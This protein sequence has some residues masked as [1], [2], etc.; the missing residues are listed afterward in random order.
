MSQKRLIG[1]ICGFAFLLTAS[2]G[3]SAQTIASSIVGTVVDATGAVIPGAHV[4][5][6][7]SGTGAVRDVQS[8]SSGVFRFPNLAPGTYSETVTANGFK[9]QNTT[10]I[11]LS[12]SETRD[13]GKIALQVGQT[14]EEV[15]VTAATTPIQT[16]SSDVSHTIGGNQLDALPLAGRDLFG[17]VH[18]D[19]GVLDTQ[20]PR[21]TTQHGALGSITID[22]STSALNFTV[23]GQTDMDTGSNGSD[24][25]EPNMD[26]IQEV[27]ILNSNS[28][29]EYGRDSGGTISVVTKSGTT[30]FHGSGWLTH[31]HEDMNANDFFHNASGLSRALY[32]YNIAGWS[33][34]GPINIGHFKNKLFFFASQEY[35]NELGSNRTETRTTPTALERSGDFSQ[36]LNSKGQL[37]KI[38]EPNTGNT[39]QY[40]GN[41]IPPAGNPACGGNEAC[42][43]PIGQAMLNFF[44]LP[45]Y[46]PAPGSKDVNQANFQQ[47]ASGANSRRNDVARFDY[48]PTSKLSMYYRWMR[49]TATDVS[50]FRMTQ[51]NI[52]PQLFE[53][54]GV[55]DQYS[56]TYVLSPTMINQASVGY[57]TDHY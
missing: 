19:A 24:K 49:D 41:V 45:N 20:G 34:G 23:D 18:L 36:S 57:G 56:L 32:R 12:A 28:Q 10:K 44:P 2:V 50:L 22:G 1:A 25:V 38:Y 46:T 11:D 7:N 43:N 39:V 13:M 27:K 4:H 53:T 54:P 31:R 6:V 8:G 3:L 48:N 29:A 16:S 30:Q 14:S 9:A 52:A 37:I 35:T 15:T 26:A 47:S 40:P 33:L 55:E 51:F 21:N 5:L 42:I 17:V